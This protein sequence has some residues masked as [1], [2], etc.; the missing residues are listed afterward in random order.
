MLLKN[1]IKNLPV[2]KELSAGEVENLARAMRVEEYPDGHVFVYQ[3]KQGKELFLLIEGEVRVCHYD[4]SG[5]SYDLKRLESGELF[6]LLSLSD[7]RPATASC[8]AAGRVKAASLPYTA[9]H[10]LF[11]S[12]AP[13]GYH[14]LFAVARQ[15]ARDLRDRADAL[16]AL[17]RHT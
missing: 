13:I 5:R 14:F 16:R 2:F 7:N 3:N 10:L 1:F 17:L 12:S 8:V 4:D 9:Y 11:Q 6:G 15:L